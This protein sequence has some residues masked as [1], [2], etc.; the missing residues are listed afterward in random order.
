MLMMLA[1]SVRTNSSRPTAYSESNAIVP[2]VLSP[3]AVCAMKPVIVWPGWVAPVTIRA[4]VPATSATII[5]SPTARDSPRMTDAA[6]PEIA[7]G[8]TTRRVVRILLAPS[9][10]EPWRR[11]IGTAL[12]ASSDSEATVGMIMI[13][14]AMPAASTLNVPTWMP[15][16]PF[17][18]SGA[19]KV[20]AKKPYTTDGTPARSSSTGLST[21]RTP[22]G[23]Y[24]DRYTAAPSPNGIA[25]SRAITVVQAV[26][27]TR[28]ST[29]Y[30]GFEKRGAH[31]VP[32]RKSITGTWRKNSSAGPRSAM[33]MPTV[34]A[35][36]SS[37]APRRPSMAMRSPLREDWRLTE[38]G[39]SG[40]P[41]RGPAID[42]TPRASDVFTSAGSAFCS[43][44]RLDGADERRS[45]LVVQRD[46]LRRG[47]DVRVVVR[48][49]PDEAG[50]L[51]L[52][53][54]RR[55]ADVD[56]QGTGQRGVRAVRSRFG[57]RCDATVPAVDLHSLERVGVLLVVPVSY[58]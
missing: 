6:M 22:V 27:V 23:A 12:I 52:V 13:P 48:V 45:L 4:C 51:W 16:R 37:A 46:V 33:T 55:L 41:T 7:A 10:K 11:A 50:D 25:R 14:S 56:E 30:V 29:P 36:E 28:G 53:G 15:S 9:A 54:E 47:G 8:N 43:A 58:T 40:R 26:P 21:L 20:N 44:E 5:V 34:I 3:V 18:T 32:D 31:R 24:S 57:A 35:I 19:M 17:S 39:R 2:G 49:V 42:G 1:I 38:V